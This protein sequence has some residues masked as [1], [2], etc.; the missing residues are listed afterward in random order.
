LITLVLGKSSLS[1]RFVDHHF[2]ESYYP[3]IE[4]TFSRVIRHKG[5]D[6]ATEIVDTAGQV[7]E[8][9]PSQRHPVH[10][11]PCVKDEYSALNSK[12]FIGI[13]GYMLVYSVASRQSFDVL[14]IIRDK[15]LNHLVSTSPFPSLLIPPY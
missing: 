1:V 6:F 13:H 3:T 4:N 5:Q 2:V 14:P 15:I 11:K 7:I 10:A 9:I 8:L 12:H